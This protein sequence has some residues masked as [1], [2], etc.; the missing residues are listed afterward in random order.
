MNRREFV[1]DM[2]LRSGLP[3]TKCNAAIDAFTT[4]LLAAMAT[5]ETVM[6]M[7]L[8]TF[9]AKQ[10]S[11]KRGW[12]PYREEH[13]TI[14]A[15]RYPVFTPSKNMVDAVREKRAYRMHSGRPMEEIYL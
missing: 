2:A 5:G 3:M 10:R 6:I 4:S 9:E 7:G 11:E 8:G 1:R 15:Y 13:M 14:P 12:D